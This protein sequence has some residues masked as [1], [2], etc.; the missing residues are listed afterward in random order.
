MYWCVLIIIIVFLFSHH[1]YICTDRKSARPTGAGPISQVHSILSLRLGLWKGWPDDLEI[2][3][4]WEPSGFMALG[5]DITCTVCSKQ[6]R[7]DLAVNFVLQCITQEVQ[8]Q[9]VSVQLQH[10]ESLQV[11]R[12]TIGTAS[13]QGPWRPK[14]FLTHTRRQVRSKWKAC[15][16]L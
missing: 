5:D 11:R 16:F 3:P 8:K 13:V 2:Y 1:L 10:K 14:T 15:F 6:N 12:G 7:M 9:A 4:I